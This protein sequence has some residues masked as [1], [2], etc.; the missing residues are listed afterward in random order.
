MSEC[1]NRYLWY[2][3]TTA[4]ASFSVASCYRPW[5]GRNVWRLRRPDKRNLNRQI[6]QRN[7]YLSRQFTIVI[8]A[9]TVTATTVTA[10]TDPTATATAPTI[11][12]PIIT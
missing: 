9:T 6:S 1:S 8:T 12:G 5:L 7:L 4:F 2:W 10:I 11:I 3:V